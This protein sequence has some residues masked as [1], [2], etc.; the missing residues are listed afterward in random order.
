MGKILLFVDNCAVHCEV[1][2]TESDA[3]GISAG[4]YHVCLAAHG[5]RNNQEPAD[6]VQ[7]APLQTK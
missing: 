4:E 7:K 1:P 3:P 5:L 6:P 2:G